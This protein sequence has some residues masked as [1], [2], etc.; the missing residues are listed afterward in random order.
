MLKL[1]KHRRFPL[2]S[3]FN[4][5]GVRLFSNEMAGETV[6]IDKA[7]FEDLVVYQKADFEI[8][9]GHY[10][11]EGR[12]NKIDHVIQHLYDTRIRFKNEKNPAQVAIKLLMNSMYGKTILKPIETQTSIKDKV[13]AYDEYVSYNYNHIESI[14]QVGDRYFIEK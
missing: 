1:N 13:E 2:L 7:G 8:V 12:N 3:K 14:T 9:D 4:E 10:F 5:D 6:Y 11:D